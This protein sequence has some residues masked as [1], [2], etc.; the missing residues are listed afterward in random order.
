MRREQ[1]LDRLILR[2]LLSFSLTSAAAFDA[3]AQEASERAMICKA[4]V[5][6]VMGRDPA[7][8]KIGQDGDEIV[9]LS[10]RRSGEQKLWS[11]RCKIVADRVIWAA[12]PGRW[13]DHP[14][15]E[16]ITYR[17]DKVKIYIAETYG[18]GS[19]T[20]KSFAKANLK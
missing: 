1:N 11:Y 19:K 17:A 2:A 4:A 18:D 13:R 3:V 5:A 14:Q 10:Y 16:R 9:S 15:D 7:I 8:I 12:D 20:E 6:T